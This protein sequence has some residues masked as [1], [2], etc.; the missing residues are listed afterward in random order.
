MHTVSDLNQ[1]K[2]L[3][4]QF[5]AKG[6]TAFVPTMGALH[7]GHASLIEKARTLADFVFVSI[8]VNP[9]QFGPGED[10][11]TYPRL[12]E[13]DCKLCRELGVDVVFMP[14]ASQM[15]ASDASTFVEETRLSKGLCGASRPGHFKGVTTV[16]LKL[17]NIV[18]PDVAVFGCKD[19]QQLC[20]IRRMV[21]DLDVDVKVVGSDTVREIDGLAV[22]SRNMFL[23]PDERKQACGIYKTLCKAQEMAG[24]FSNDP[25]GLAGFVKNGIEEIPVVGSVDY[26]EIKDAVTLE[27]VEKISSDVVVLV[28]ARVGTTRLID[29]IVIK[30]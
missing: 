15:Y 27:P 26:V 22:S 24:K 17:F 21:R 9:T 7:K 19:Y 16:V 28:A 8:F 2:Q 11:G 6:T 29:N 4:R 1:A 10:F 25:A 5:K 23:T 20:V 13:A 18:N 14:L 12:G 3:F 30:V